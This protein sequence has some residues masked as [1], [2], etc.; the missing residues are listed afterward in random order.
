MIRGAFGRRMSPLV[1]LKLTIFIPLFSFAFG[2]KN[3][4]MSL[5]VNEWLPCAAYS[6]NW[7]EIFFLF[8]RSEQ[9]PLVWEETSRM[10]SAVLANIMVDA[11]RQISWTLKCSAVGLLFICKGCTTDVQERKYAIFLIIRLKLKKYYFL[12]CISLIDS[13]LP[14]VGVTELDNFCLLSSNGCLTNSCILY[15]SAF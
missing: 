7:S 1:R 5:R 3:A 15:F 6:G 13:T 2:L 12:S 8:R 10:M 11:F 14:S 9:P 4:W